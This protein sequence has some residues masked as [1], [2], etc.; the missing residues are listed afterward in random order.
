MPYRNVGGVYRGYGYGNG[1]G[2]RGYG[3]VAPRYYSSNYF[4]GGAAPSGYGYGGYSAP[5]APGVGYVTTIAPRC[6]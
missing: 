1:F 2:Y 5:I 4:Y 6:S 3:A